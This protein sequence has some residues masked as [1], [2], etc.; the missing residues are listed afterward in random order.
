MILHLFVLAREQGSEK[1]YLV[2]II[3]SMYF[4]HHLMS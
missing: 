4:T 1:G 2:L 3:A